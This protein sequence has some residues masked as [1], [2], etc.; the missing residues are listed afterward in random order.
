LK[1]FENFWKIFPKIKAEIFSKMEIFEGQNS[2]ISF[3]A[4]LSRSG[5]N[6]TKRAVRNLAVRGPLIK[7]KLKNE[8]IMTELK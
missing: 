5:I 1:N 3:E 2:A 8:I 7:I 6:G 4:D